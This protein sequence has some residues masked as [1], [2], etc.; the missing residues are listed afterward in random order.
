MKLKGVIGKIA[1][2][3]LERGSVTIEEP[4]EDIYARYLGGYGLGAYYLYTRQ[5]AGIDPSF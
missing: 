2:V 4:G 1:W 5:K 3:D